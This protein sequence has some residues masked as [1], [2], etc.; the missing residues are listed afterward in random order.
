MW[1]HLWGNAIAGWSGSVVIVFG[2]KV[3]YEAGSSESKPV[4][5][6]ERPVWLNTLHRHSLLIF[7]IVTGIGWTISFFYE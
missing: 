4:K 2:P 3:L 7:I 5:S 1:A 6:K